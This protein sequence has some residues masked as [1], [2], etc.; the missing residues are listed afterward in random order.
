MLTSLAHFLK[1]ITQYRG[2][3]YIFAAIIFIG[4]SCF[5]EQK[6][7]DVVNGFIQILDLVFAFV[8]FLMTPAI[9]L[10]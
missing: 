8:S 1:K 7:S 9:I 6:D 10:A 2:F 5:A 3:K 4:G